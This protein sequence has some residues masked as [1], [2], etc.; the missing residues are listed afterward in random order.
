MNEK[1]NRITK[2]KM[3]YS[4]VMIAS[5]IVLGGGTYLAISQSKKENTRPKEQ[6]R[7]IVIEE[8]QPKSKVKNERSV[9]SE[10]QSDPATTVYDQFDLVPNTLFP[11]SPIF[12]TSELNEAYLTL[13]NSSPMSSELNVPQASIPITNLPIIERPSIDL[14]E[15]NQPENESLPTPEPLWIKPQLVSNVSRITVDQGSQ[16]IPEEYFIIR[17]GSD[18]LPKLTISSIDT[19]IL[20]QQI[21]EIMVQDSRGYQSYLSIPVLINSLPTLQLSE[22]IRTIHIG[23]SI[24]LM[25]GIQASD[26]EDGDLSGQVRYTTD[27]NL[28]KEG[29]YTVNYVVTDSSG[30]STTIQ[31]TIH[32]INDAP[33]IHAPGTI[34]HQAK[35]F[36]DPLEQ[37]SVTDTEDGDIHLTAANVLENYVNIHKEGVYKVRI[38]HVRDKYGKAATDITYYVSIVNQAP[39][40]SQADLTSHVFTDITK[41]E[42]IDQLIYS[43]RE[44]TN[45]ELSVTID[46][47]AW[48]AVNTSIPGIYNVPVTVTDSLGKSSTAEG[49]ITIIND[50]PL[51]EGVTDREIKVGDDSFD[52]LE[53]INVSDTE[54][55]LTL[56][57][58]EVTGDFDVNTPGV[59]F[60]TLTISDSFDT[61][62]ISY[63][64]T[65]IESD[66]EEHE[67]I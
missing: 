29:S 1:K 4:L 14:P 54:E 26:V 38:G 49:R 5:V 58:I 17:L 56:E 50:N 40:I 8:I 22:P 24:N 34:E 19:T 52:P 13:V 11:L 35:S 45:E 37:V 67:T 42:F 36:F 55:M 48:Q 57:D 27:L 41:E 33:I 15:T 51:I 3:V 47:Q 2:R 18:S 59:Y 16:F 64:L 66:E 61:V 46:E 25:S 44:D 23:S 62:Q 60:I 28:E 30:S 65:V 20:G 9:P 12:E 7:T 43:D 6:T 63:T 32:V 10:K 53:G 21:L 39:V 31:G